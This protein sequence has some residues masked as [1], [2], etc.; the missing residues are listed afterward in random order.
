MRASLRAEG[1][2]RA[3]PSNELTGAA[4]RELPIISWT[5]ASRAR[6]GH[7]F[8][9]VAECTPSRNSSPPSTARST[10]RL[11]ELEDRTGMAPWNGVSTRAGGAACG[12]GLESSA[13]VEPRRESRP[14][15]TITP[16]ARSSLGR[17]PREGQPSYATPIQPRMR[18]AS[19]RAGLRHTTP[20]MGTGSGRLGLEAL[21][22]DLELRNMLHIVML[23]RTRG[24]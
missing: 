18:R 6:S 23:S 4:I 9:T 10:P 12:R 3:S 16:L 15:D 19:A 2:P 21:R 14:S 1:N 17:V 7:R 5:G 8:F 13:G 20:R 11:G 24:A 22:V